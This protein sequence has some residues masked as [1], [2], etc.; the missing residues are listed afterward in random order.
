M[1]SDFLPIDRLTYVSRMSVRSWTSRKTENGAFLE[2]LRFALNENLNMFTRPEFS[3]R[4]TPERH[5]KS[6]GKR[7]LLP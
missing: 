5:K 3:E 6:G 7:P 4:Q 2:F 1:G